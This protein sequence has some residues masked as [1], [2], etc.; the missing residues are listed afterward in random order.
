M[1]AELGPIVPG[2]LASEERQ[3][4]AGLV[5][6]KYGTARWNAAR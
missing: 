5:E 4:A 6:E 1:A 2:E 3:L